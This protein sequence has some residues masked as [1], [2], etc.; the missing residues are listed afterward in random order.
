MG[1]E[2]TRH[3]RVSSMLFPLLP[4]INAGIDEADPD[5]YVLNMF[6]QLKILYDNDVVRFCLRIKLFFCRK[7]DQTT[8]AGAARMWVRERERERK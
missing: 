8:S 2:G 3:G 5:N 4:F 6:M 7:R 1:C